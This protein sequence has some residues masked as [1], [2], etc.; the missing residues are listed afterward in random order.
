MTE[1]KEAFCLVEPAKNLTK[2]YHKKK[3]FDFTRVQTP[4]RSEFINVQIELEM[5]FV[6]LRIPPLPTGTRGGVNQ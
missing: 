3:Q 4:V 1:Q 2:N 6:W 5:K